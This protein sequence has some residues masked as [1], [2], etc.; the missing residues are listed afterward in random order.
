MHEGITLIWSCCQLASSCK[1]V[2]SETCDGKGWRESHGGLDWSSGHLLWQPCC[3]LGGNWRLEQAVTFCAIQH[4]ATRLVWWPSQGSVTLQSQ[5]Q[6]SACCW[7]AHEETAPWAQSCF[8]KDPGECALSP[9]S[10]CLLVPELSLVST[11]PE[12][13]GWRPERQPCALAAT[14][15]AVLATSAAGAVAKS[16]AWLLGRRRMPACRTVT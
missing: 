3:F 8:K 16:P 14:W 9:P 6:G 12:W 4:Q 7:Q 11:G 15:V 13:R 10:V 1:P 2:A 5:H